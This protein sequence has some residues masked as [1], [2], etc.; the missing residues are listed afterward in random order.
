MDDPLKKIISIEKPLERN[1][2]ASSQ[3]FDGVSS[4]C[5][6]EMMIDGNGP[7]ISSLRK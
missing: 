6:L 5:S 7:K 4:R 1:Q 2:I 3:S